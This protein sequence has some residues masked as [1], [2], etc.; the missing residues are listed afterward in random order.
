MIIAFIVPDFLQMLRRINP[1]NTNSSTIG[2]IN[3]VTSKNVKT[4][5]EKNGYAIVLF[6]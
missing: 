1:R 3:T 6:A 2:A 4:R 5:K